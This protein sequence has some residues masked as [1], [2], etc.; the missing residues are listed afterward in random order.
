MLKADVHLRFVAIDA[1][2]VLTQQMLFACDFLDQ[3]YYFGGT[4]QM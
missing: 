2:D 1:G 4:S 3:H